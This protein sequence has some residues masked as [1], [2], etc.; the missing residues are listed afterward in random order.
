M[1]PIDSGPVRIKFL[2][3]SLAVKRSVL[4][5]LLALGAFGLIAQTPALGPEFQVNT[6]TTNP[7]SHPSAA[8]AADGCVLVA[9]DSVGQD[10][11][12]LGVVARVYDPHGV[13]KTAEL[14]VNTYTT[15]QQ[16]LPAI[17]CRPNCDF[18][19]AW[20][21]NQDGD[22]DGIFGQRFNEDGVAQ[23]GEFA[24]NTFTTS[25]QEAPAVDMDSAG[26]FVIV[27]MS[28]AG[29]GSGFGISG[30]RFNTA[31]APLGGEFVVNTTTSGNQM[32][33]SVAMALGGEFV[34]VWQSPDQDGDQEGIFA[35]RYD[36]SGNAI[37]SEIP[38][39]TY[40]TNR[41]IRASV[42]I[43]ASGGFV[44]AW[45]SVGQDGDGSGVFARR[46]DALG[47]PVTEELA[48]SAYTTADQR[49]PRVA[50]MEDGGFLAVWDGAGPGGSS[51]QTWARRFAADSTA[52]DDAFRVNIFEASNNQTNPAAASDPRGGFA[53]VWQSLVQDGDNFGIFARRGGFPDGRPMDVDQRA[54]G[55][56]SSNLNGVLESEE[57]VTVDPFWRNGSS[58][59]LPL[60]GTAHDLTGP[61]GPVYTIND[62]TAAYGPIAAGSTNGCFDVSGNCYEMRV[63]GA[64]PAPHWD[65]TFVEDL[66]PQGVLKTWTLHVGESFTDVPLSNLFYKFVETIFHGRITAGGFCG[67]YCPDD[68]TLRKQMAVFVLKAKEGPFFVPPPAT[69]IFHDVPASDPFA[70]WIEELFRR[71]VVAGCGTPGGPNYCPDDPVLRD[72]MAV[73]LLRTLEGAAYVPPACS[74]IFDDVECPGLF[75]DFIEELSARAIAAGC[76]GANYCPRNPTT[77]GQMAPFLVKTFGLV[78]YGP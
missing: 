14:Q 26:N 45:E 16:Q 22:S 37:S 65:A 49:R 9:W 40:T 71:G 35:R 52:R 72:Q 61:S 34:V 39:N 19:V 13:P 1:L 15:G 69:G 75:T 66:E 28:F 58:T 4:V 46:F 59:L 27:W 17:A 44:V 11:S 68:V 20:Q 42:G 64:R 21:S 6:Y 55:S 33:P 31:G 53:I 25:T 62:S 3:G 10:G 74:G 48:L 32:Y 43:E 67:G 7:Q 70:P 77:R 24:V 2:M 5:I 60:T 73:F 78:L 63:T 51:N 23:G 30:Q 29:D 41:Q 12:Q 76:G 38:V 56:G 18:V 57:T 36:S 8:M 54:A 47:V 50:G